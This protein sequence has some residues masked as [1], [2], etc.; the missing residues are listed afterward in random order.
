[1]NESGER[2]GEFIKI[3]EEVRGK[4]EASDE[5]TTKMVEK[6]DEMKSAVAE[7]VRA[8]DRMEKRVKVKEKELVA[9][10]EKLRT[11]ALE[12]L[13]AAKE[14]VWSELREKLGGVDVLA[15]K[16][17]EVEKVESECIELSTEIMALREKGK[18][19]GRTIRGLKHDIK[20]AAERIVE[21]TLECEKAGIENINFR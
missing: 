1:M 10:V 3:I 8:R 7:G 9:G 14:K 5:R 4:L 13:D 16:E 18:G 12:E 19:D 2:A 6:I 17:M 20:R 15:V 21:M 11:S